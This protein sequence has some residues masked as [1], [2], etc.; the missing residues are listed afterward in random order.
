MTIAPKSCPPARKRFALPLRGLLLS[1]PILLLACSGPQSQE[2]PPVP[3][4][5][6]VVRTEPI[7]NIIE[8]P[9]RLQAI[10]TA[11]VRARVTGIVDKLAY[12]E[13]SEIRAGQLLFR[14]D[15]REMEADVNAA[16]AAL[17]RAEASAHNA[18][19]DV[20]RYQPLLKEQA[21]SQQEYDAAMTRMHSAEADVQQARAQLARARLDLGYT[22]VTSP[23]SGRVGRALVTEGALVSASEATLL[24]VVEQINPIYVNFAQAS[25]DLLAVRRD[26]ESGKLN[27]PSFESV[28]VEL[29]LEDGTTFS[30]TGRLDFLS[31]SL[32]MSTDSAELRAEFPN[33]GN[34]LLPGQFVRAR[35]F[36]GTRQD[37]ILVPQR[38]VN[39]TANGG[40]VLVVNA[41]GNAEA[42][43]VG[44][45]DLRG[46]NWVV[47]GGLKPGD[48]VIISNLQKVQAGNPVQIVESAMAPK[49]EDSAPDTAEDDDAAGKS[50]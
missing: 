33:P 29:E 23:I 46:A 44:L 14:I 9:A 45:G 26:V 22:N 20:R 12:R 37:A 6:A 32:D 2:M 47:T 5:V 27:I 30:Q 18:R 10:R 38:A 3:V 21:I 36:A 42:R 1:L 49:G 13:G 39:V 31:P 7:A 35:I 24:T 28:R 19:Q 40:M 8:L 48:Q 25:S 34:M 50:R 11:Q 4:Q 17:Q 43:P 41:E 16:Q 15:P